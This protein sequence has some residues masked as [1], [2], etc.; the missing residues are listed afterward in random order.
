MGKYYSTT[1]DACFGHGRNEVGMAGIR[2]S[3]ESKLFQKFLNSEVVLG[4]RP[5]MMGQGIKDEPDTIATDGMFYDKEDIIN[6]CR[7]YSEDRNLTDKDI[8]E[9]GFLD[10]TN[11]FSIY[12]VA[13]F[14][15]R[16]NKVILYLIKKELPNQLQ[17]KDLSWTGDSV[18]G[19]LCNSKFYA[20][21]LAENGL[22]KNWCLN[23]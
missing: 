8:K 21:E 4:T 15:T 7:N 9:F 11:L 6:Y 1:V 5:G 12:R 17:V 16:N 22:F 2:I 18:N 10:I 14:Y 3:M 19:W 20:L 13:N 23:N